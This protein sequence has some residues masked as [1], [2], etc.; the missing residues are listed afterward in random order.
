MN[1]TRVLIVDDDA[2]TLAL[3]AIALTASG[4]ATDKAATGREALAAVHRAGPQVIITDLNLPDCN[5]VELCADMRA[6]GGSALLG[7]IVLS[8]NSDAEQHA[9]ARQAGAAEVL[10]KPCL[11]SDLEGAIR[12]TLANASAKAESGG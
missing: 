7:I 11:P 4:F 5:G 1:M 6:A 9:R 10:V 12:K 8:G 3:Y 2:D